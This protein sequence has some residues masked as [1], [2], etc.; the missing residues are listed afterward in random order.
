LKVTNWFRIQA[1]TLNFF[2]LEGAGESGKSTIAKQMKII[3]L[4]GFSPEELLAYKANLQFNAI[5]CMRALVLATQR[6][7]Y[8]LKTENEVLLKFTV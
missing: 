4:N 3:H 7:G 8:K 1:L 5:Q 2:T 6:Y